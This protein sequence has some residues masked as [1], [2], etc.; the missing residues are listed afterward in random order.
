MG[1]PGAYTSAPVASY[2]ISGEENLNWFQSS[3]NAQRGSCR[4]CGSKLFWRAAGEASMDVSLG[5]L[6][7]PTGLQLALHIWTRHQ[8]DYY[9]IDRDGVP[10]YAESSRGQQPVPPE[11][12]PPGGPK[13]SLHSGGCEC[14]AVKYRVTGNMRDVVVC[15]CGQ[16]RRSHG[17]AP[18]YSAARRSEMEIA[19]E[20]EIG[21][22]RSSD[23]ARRGFCRQCGSSLFWWHDGKAVLSVTAGSI[24]APTGLK[25]VRHIYA[26]NK[27][28]YYTIADGVP[29]SP[30][31]MEGDPVTF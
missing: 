1:A 4:V 9:E 6:D 30:G 23:Q 27:S 18:G 29:Q 21:W 16:C 26:A 10:R 19:G 5:A 13:T 15:H 25:T 20:A 22:Y 2:R 8:G 17:H 14:G 12:A 11:P 24:D 28:D 31:T 7:V 3:A